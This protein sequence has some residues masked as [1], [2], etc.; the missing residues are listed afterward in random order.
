MSKTVEA[1]RHAVLCVLEALPPGTKLRMDAAK[2]REI[3]VS[4]GA[5]G[6]DATVVPLEEAPLPTARELVRAGEGI[7]SVREAAEILGI[8]R[9]AV[10]AAIR[11]GVLQAQKFG[12]TYQVEAVSVAEYQRRRAVPSDPGGIQAGGVAAS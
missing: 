6:T 1:S 12:A 10:G 3:L 7:I 9:Q 4:V 5:A 2:L 8:T 11:R